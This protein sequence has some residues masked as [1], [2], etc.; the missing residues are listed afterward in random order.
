VGRHGSGIG[1]SGGFAR[2]VLPGVARGPRTD[3]R[4]IYARSL[5]NTGRAISGASRSS[6]TCG[7][8]S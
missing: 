5:G 2:D 6:A 1:E 3:R 8:V 7:H 4:G